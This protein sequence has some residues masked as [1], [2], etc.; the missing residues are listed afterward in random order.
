MGDL[1]RAGALESLHG[2][3][4]QMLW[5][6]GDLQYQEEA[7]GGGAYNRGRSA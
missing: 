4:R 2:D 6:L 7:V 1:I 5:A 3:R